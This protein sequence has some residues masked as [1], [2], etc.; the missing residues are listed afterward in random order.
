MGGTIEVGR[1]AG[2]E[3]KSRRTGDSG[4]ILTNEEYVGGI[5]KLVEQAEDVGYYHRFMSYH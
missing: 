3:I 4:T 1:R 2:R 5:L